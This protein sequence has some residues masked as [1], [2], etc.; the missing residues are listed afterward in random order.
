VPADFGRDQRAVDLQGLAYFDVRH[1]PAKPFSVRVSGAVIDDIGTRF[2]AHDDADGSVSVSVT[3]GI[4]RLRPANGTAADGR[5][6]RVG[7]RGVVDQ[8]GR[9]RA[10]PGGASADDLAWT[11]GQL[12]FRESPFPHVVNE[13]RRW[14]GIELRAGDSALSTRR[15]NLTATFTTEPPDQ[16]LKVIGLDLGARIERRGDTAIVHLLRGRSGPQ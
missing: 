15:L 12:V 7:D 11:R 1:D 13:L 16:V 2:V 14:Y 8:S 10:F 4:V 3:D 6:L 9:T 5:I